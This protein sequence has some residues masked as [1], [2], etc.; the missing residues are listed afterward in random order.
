MV[1]LQCYTE[2]S[3]SLL[4]QVPPPPPPPSSSPSSEATPPQALAQLPIES[5]VS[6][7]QWVGV[8]CAGSGDRTG[9]VDSAW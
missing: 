5:L 7:L 1:S 3:L 2:E 8:A 6:S 9:R 4:V